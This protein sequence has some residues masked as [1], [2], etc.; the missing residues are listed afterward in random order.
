M[1][2][3][4]AAKDGTSTFP[5]GVFNF[6]VLVLEKLRIAPLAM[7]A[8]FLMKL[9]KS[10]DVLRKTLLAGLATLAEN[11]K[12]LFNEISIIITSAKT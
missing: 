4:M 10:S 5:A 6:T 9:S 3:T 12:S 1:A 8:G 11:W 2:F 7:S